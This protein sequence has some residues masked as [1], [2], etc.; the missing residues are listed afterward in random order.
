M[1]LREPGKVES[2]YD[3]FNSPQSLGQA[4][5]LDL[6]FIRNLG[7]IEE[8]RRNL[9]VGQQKSG[10]GLLSLLPQNLGLIPC[11]HSYYDVS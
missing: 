3:R 2:V 7:K 11:R 5:F 10:R 1:P 4:L 6:D 9:N 8:A